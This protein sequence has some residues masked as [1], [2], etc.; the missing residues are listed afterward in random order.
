MTQT[1]TVAGFIKHL[2]VLEADMHAAESAILMKACIMIAT[3]AKEALGTYEF[4]WVSLAPATIAKKVR[5]DSPLLETGKL[6]DSI[7][8]HVEGRHG[9][10]GTDLDEG[11]W[12]EFGTSKIPARSFLAAAAMQQEHL[13]HEMAVKAVRAVMRGEHMPAELREFLH[14]LH[15]VK[16]AAE[17]LEQAIPEADER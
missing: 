8:Y 6:R 7:Q 16:H 10:V 17:K 15:M 5:G 1:F 12:M 9:E 14:V 11:L 2:A 4:G 13:I 3:A